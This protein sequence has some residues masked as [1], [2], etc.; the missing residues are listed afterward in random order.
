MSAA[1][2]TPIEPPRT[3]EPSNARELYERAK[4]DI[5]RPSAQL[6]L[7]WVFR[8]AFYVGKAEV[9][10]SALK[11]VEQLDWEVHHRALSFVDGDAMRDRYEAARP[12]VRLKNAEDMVIEASAMVVAAAGVLALL[13]AVS[14]K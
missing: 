1:E 11:R 14:S 5:A 10:R 7:R 4:I 13:A 3:K 8:H 2:V 9:A 6:H 12:T